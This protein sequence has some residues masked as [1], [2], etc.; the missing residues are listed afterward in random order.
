MLD[1]NQQAQS[2]QRQ[3]STTIKMVWETICDT[4][5]V[6]KQ[7]YVGVHSRRGGSQK[8]L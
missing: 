1:Q 2:E 3:N 4:S 5:D 6:S 7:S 8:K